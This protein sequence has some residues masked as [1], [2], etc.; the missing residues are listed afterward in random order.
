[1]TFLELYTEGFDRMGVTVAE[2]DADDLSMMKRFANEAAQFVA[3]ALRLPELEKSAG[4]T[5][6][7]SGLTA[8][9]SWVA[10]VNEVYNVSNVPLDKKEPRTFE[11]L[12]RGDTTAATDPSVYRVEGMDASGN[13]QISTWPVI[14]STRA[15]TVKGIRRIAVMS[16][17]GD[18]PEIPAE[19]HFLIVD[20]MVALY[21]EWEESEAAGIA[22]SRSES[23]IQRASS[24]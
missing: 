8:L 2:A 15:G 16:A 5:F 9:P 14:S 20:R 3:V 23:G 24:V 7:T 17:D 4:I 6:L 21:R 18:V 10:A 11:D 22:G 1:M 19:K 12:Y 13:L